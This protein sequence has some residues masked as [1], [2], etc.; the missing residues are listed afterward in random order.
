MHLV[1]CSAPNYAKV[2]PGMLLVAMRLSYMGL[3][4]LPSC[5]Y[6]QVFN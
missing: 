6:E 2:Q 4:F 1:L 5:L 3:I